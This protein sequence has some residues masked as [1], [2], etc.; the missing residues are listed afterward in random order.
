MVADVP[1]GAFLSGG[2]DSSLVVALMQAQA[3]RPVK[4]FSIGFHEAGYN[5]AH[6][7]KDVA[8]ALKT[9]H[10]ELYVESH[11]AQEVIPSIPRWCDEP[12]ADVSQIPPISCQKWPEKSHRQLSGDGG[13]ELFGG[14][15]RY[16]LG[17]KLGKIFLLLPCGSVTL[18][19]RVYKFLDPKLGII[20]QNLYR[21]ACDPVYWVTR[22]IR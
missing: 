10:H 8:K 6:Y 13:D 11:V 17:Q 20:W 22:F 14:Y 19:L 15:T 16:F 18:S 12:F 4:T 3:D 7:A 2:I 9:D 1:L 5:E 21:R